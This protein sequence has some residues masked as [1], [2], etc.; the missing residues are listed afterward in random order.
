[1]RKNVKK[2]VCVMMAAVMILAMGVTAFA[3]NSPTV[4]GVV[5]AQSGKDANG[6]AITFSLRRPDASYNSAIASLQ[7]VEGLKA[8]LGANYYAGMEVVDV[9]SITLDQSDVTYPI[10]LTFSVPGVVAGTHV[11]VLAYVNGEWVVLDCVVGNGTITVTFA[12]ADQLKCVAFVVDKST[13]TGSTGKVSP[14]TGET[15]TIPAMAAAAVVLMIGG[16]YCL[17]KREVR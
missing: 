13:A 3:A 6:R 11:A 12:N 10:T 1:M 4:N 2:I 17:R 5:K 14:K 15:T 7:S 9:R 8:V 16:I